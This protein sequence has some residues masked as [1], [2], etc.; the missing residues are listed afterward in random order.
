LLFDDEVEMK[1]LGWNFNSNGG[2]LIGRETLVRFHYRGPARS[3]RRGPSTSLE[4]GL[5]RNQ[6]WAL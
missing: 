5:R 1:A 4:R 6:L 2:V 3:T